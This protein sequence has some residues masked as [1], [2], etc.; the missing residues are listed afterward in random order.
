VAESSKKKEAKMLNGASK[1]GILASLVKVLALSML[2]QLAAS[3]QVAA[4]AQD[5]NSC[6][7]RD[8]VSPAKSLVYLLCEQGGLMVTT[9]A[10][11]TWSNRDTGTKGHMRNIEFSDA[12]HGFAVGDD[13]LLVAT[14]DGG[15]TWE[16]RKTGVTEN[17]T[18]IQFV[19]QSGWATGYDGVILHTADGGATWAPQTTG[20]KESL[21]NLF[22]LD[23][24]RGWAVGWAGTILRTTD[25]GKT[26]Q[27][28]KT[29]AAQWSLTS[30]YFRDA[31]YGWTVGFDG[32]ILRSR[33]GG[34]T[35]TAQASPV[36][37]SLSSILFDSSNRGWITA[38]ATLLVSEDAGE[39]WKNVSGVDDQLFLC[40]LITVNGSPWAIGQ[41]GVL[42]QTGL[43]AEWKKIESLVP[44]DPL[45]DAYTGSLT[46][47]TIPN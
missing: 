28:V 25:G 33:D 46:A 7:L 41:L 42:R 9:D 21:E 29:D 16:P 2:W 15:K 24:E 5:Q 8:G 40:Q 44:D 11:T 19:G 23:A 34:V 39:S 45:R 6:W 43:S 37:S 1:G 32:Q 27:Q 30:V 13:G 38:D 36:K 3:A 18:A 14:A 12:N 47:S 20:T 35:W 26:W 17:L 10:G 31:N 22:F 4:S